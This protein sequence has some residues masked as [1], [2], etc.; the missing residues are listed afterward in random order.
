MLNVQCL[1][2]TTKLV[3]LEAKNIVRRTATTNDAVTDDD[4]DDDDE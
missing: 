3:S 1:F 2:L 4:D